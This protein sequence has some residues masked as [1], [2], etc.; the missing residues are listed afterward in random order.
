MDR[1]Q[2][3]EESI[4]KIGDEIREDIKCEIEIDRDEMLQG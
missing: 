4:R 1:E 2:T 3:S